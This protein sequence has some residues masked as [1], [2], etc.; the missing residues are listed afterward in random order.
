MIV[1][2]TLSAVFTT[3]FR[4]LIIGISALI[5]AFYF[6][7]V[8]PGVFSVPRQQSYQSDPDGVT[9]IYQ[10]KIHKLEKELNAKGRQVQRSEGSMNREAKD[11]ADNSKACVYLNKH[12]DLFNKD[13]VTLTVDPNKPESITLW[14]HAWA[15]IDYFINTPLRY[16]CN[17]RQM[18]GNWGICQDEPFGVKPP[19]L[20]YSFGIHWDFSFDDAMGKL[21]CEVH[22]FDPSMGKEVKY[23]TEHK[24][25]ANVSFHPLGL[26]PSHSIKRKKMRFRFRSKREH[27]RYA[28]SLPRANALGGKLD[29]SAG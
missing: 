26:T 3:N 7:F 16:R 2:S 23:K 8:Y 28:R 21:G 11:V 14:W 22:S 17:K 13:G 19:C 6:M 1:K 20:V 18:K 29:K 15:M 5:L 4:M 27:K 9:S 25:N 24:R 10:R 12:K